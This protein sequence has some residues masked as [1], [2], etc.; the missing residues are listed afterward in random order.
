[1]LSQEYTTFVCFDIINIIEDIFI[2]VG[3]HKRL[4]YF[5]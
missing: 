1:M 5:Y 2:F 3:Y 4:D